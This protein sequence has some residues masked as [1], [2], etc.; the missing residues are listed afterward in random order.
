[1]MFTSSW[2]RPPS[3]RPRPTTRLAIEQLEDRCVPSAGNGSYLL[4]SSSKTDNVLRYD[5]ATGAFVD[6]FIPHRDGRLNQPGSILIGP[7]DHNVYVGTGHFQGPGQI[8]AVLR[9]DGATGAF[10]DEFVQR[11]QLTQPGAAVFGPDGNIYVNDS[12]TTHQ[13]RVARFDGTT[14][15][16]L[17]D[18]V[19]VGSG[20]LGHTVSLVFGPSGRGAGSLDLYV[21]DED[22]GSILRYDGTTGAFLGVFV[23]GGSGGLGTSAGFVF[24][25]DG[26]FYVADGGFFGSTPAVLR[27]QGAAGP[28]PG[29]FMGAFVPAGRGGLLQPFGVLFGPDRNGDGR[30]DLYVTSTQVNDSSFANSKPHTSSVKVYDGVTG[31]YLSDFVS[32]DSGGL[33]EPTL[34]TFTETDPVTLAYQGGNA[35]AAAALPA[36]PP[37]QALSVPQARP[38]LSE[39]LP[40]RHAAGA[41]TPG[42]GNMPSQITSLG[43]ATVGLACGVNAASWG[44]FIDPTPADESEFRLPGDQGEQQRIDLLMVLEHELGHLLGYGHSDTDQMNPTLATGLRETPM[45]RLDQLFATWA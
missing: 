24:G 45:G 10:L 15:A 39:A 18:F 40:R 31:A 6:E 1:M 36:G 41:G 14:G 17:D 38:V 16:Y 19:P 11:G 22:T 33:N 42:P 8:K 43:G 37:N 4:V 44:W 13:G 5:T 2:F 20:G 30:Q 29:A 21:N 32:V 9:Y 28:T 26:N 7:K 12:F 35:L 34:M 27:F 23:S 25:P 3:K